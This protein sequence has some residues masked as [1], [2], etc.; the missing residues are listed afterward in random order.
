[1]SG[2]CKFEMSARAARTHLRDVVPELRG[3]RRATDEDEF[4]HHE[5]LR[6]GHLDRDRTLRF[7]DSESA[8]DYFHSTRRYLVKELRLEG[9]DTLEAGN[10]YLPAFMERFNAKFAQTPANATDLHRPLNEL[11]DL[12]EILSRQEERTVSNSLTLQYDRVVYLLEPTELAK[13]LRRNRVRVHAYPNGTVAI[14]YQGVDL[15]YRVCPRPATR[16]SGHP[17]H[18]RPDAARTAAAG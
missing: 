7:V 8:F 4:T 13:G 6:T 2:L 1:M 14:K 16:A 10:A 5:H 12:E 18:L 11:D 15:P 3:L 17:Q 9:S